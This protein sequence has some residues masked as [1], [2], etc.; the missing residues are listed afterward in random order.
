M[1]RPRR[2]VKTSIR[3]GL[4]WTHQHQT[5]CSM[6]GLKRCASIVFQTL[7]PTLSTRVPCTLTERRVGRL[8]IRSAVTMPSM[9]KAARTSAGRWMERLGKEF[10]DF[11]KSS[12]GKGSLSALLSSSSST[13]IPP[14]EPEECRA[15]SLRAI[16]ALLFLFLLLC[17]ALSTLTSLI[18]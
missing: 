14:R 10:D 15:T 11:L 9:W 5:A 8:G 16:A 2:P 12:R 4:R 13:I 17:I 7:S 18:P 1:P 6:W 3:T